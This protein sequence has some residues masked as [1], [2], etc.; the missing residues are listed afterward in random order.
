MAAY[1][2]LKE[3]L[4]DPD[5]LDML[6]RIEHA[7]WVRF[8]AYCNWRHGTVKDPEKHE[9]PMICEYEELSEDQKAYHDTAWEL[10]EEIAKQLS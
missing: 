4:K 1:E 6:R 5:R 3:A 10:I 2:A 8:Y 9:N 7:R